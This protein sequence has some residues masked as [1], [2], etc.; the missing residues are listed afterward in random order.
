M[1]REKK[2][3]PVRINNRMK[4][5]GKKLFADLGTNSQQEITKFLELC[6]ENKELPFTPTM[7]VLP[8]YTEKD[9]VLQIGLEEEVK[10]EARKVLKTLEL[11]LSP[12][13]ILFIRECLIRQTIPYKK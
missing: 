12:A 11:K 8:E 13:I 7:K 3:F 10:E 2:N 6:I 5:D 4:E 9:A 1:N